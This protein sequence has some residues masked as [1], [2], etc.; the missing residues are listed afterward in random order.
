MKDQLSQFLGLCLI[1]AIMG[2]ILTVQICN[3]N[4]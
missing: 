1:L 4:N 3:L 2:L